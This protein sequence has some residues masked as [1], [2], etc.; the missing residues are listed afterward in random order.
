MF[1]PFLIKDI[2]LLLDDILDM[3]FAIVKLIIHLIQS[4]FK[5]FIFILKIINFYFLSVVL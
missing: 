3:S 2:F 5:I 1:F 4:F